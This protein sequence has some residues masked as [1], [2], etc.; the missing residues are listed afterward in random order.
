[1]TKGSVW[2]KVCKSPAVCAPPPGKK[3][4][5]KE[6]PLSVVCCSVLL[7]LH[8]KLICLWSVYLLSLLALVGLHDLVDLGDP[9]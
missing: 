9:R 4:L 3:I 7:K 8:L 2:V 1:M 6:M 5:V